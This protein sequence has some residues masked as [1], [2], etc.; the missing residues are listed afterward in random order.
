MLNPQ[1]QKALHE[2]KA[3][4]A[5]AKAVTRSALAGAIEQLGEV[6]LQAARLRRAAQMSAL[7]EDDDEL[8]AKF[9]NTQRVA[10]HLESLC[11]EATVIHA[12]IIATARQ[13]E[14]NEAD[15]RATATGKGYAE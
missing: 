2:M 14:R 4:G 13:L 5:D 1:I 15:A 12:K 11:G 8:Q 6:K 9:D 7:L 10:A 3:H